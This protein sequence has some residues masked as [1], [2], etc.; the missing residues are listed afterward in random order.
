MIPTSPGEWFCAIL[1]VVLVLENAYE[2]FFWNRIAERH[3]KR[4][5]EDV[6]WNRNVH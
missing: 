5:S 1:L 2:F 6:K 4:T 3:Y